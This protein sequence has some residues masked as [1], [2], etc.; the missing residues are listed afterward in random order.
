MQNDHGTRHQLNSKYICHAIIALSLELDSVVAIGPDMHSTTA[1][2]FL[3][4][5]SHAISKQRNPYD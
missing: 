1:P 5:V 3:G 4:V 2:T